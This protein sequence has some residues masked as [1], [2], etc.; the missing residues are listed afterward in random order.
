MNV[1]DLANQWVSY[2]DHPDGAAVVADADSVLGN[3]ARDDPEACWH[4]I[5]AILER[6][7]ADPSN[8]AF[9]VLAAGPLEDLL[10]EHGPAVIASVE[11]QARRDPKLNLLLGGVWQNAISND[12]WSRVQAIRNAVW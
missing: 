5:L 9:Q 2:W 6:I 7:E 11:L 1:S 10:A 8:K 4:T 12:V 3:L